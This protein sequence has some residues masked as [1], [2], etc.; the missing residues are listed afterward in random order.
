MSTA[1]EQS[2]QAVEAFWAAMN[3][4]DFAAAA[5]HLS[6]DFVLE[7]PQSRERIRGR[8]NFAAINQSYPANGRWQFT[9]HRLVAEGAE[10]VSDVG[11]TDGSVHARAITFSTVRDG[12][13]VRQIEYW[14]DAYEAPAWRAQWVERM[15]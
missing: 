6:E 14:P 2:R 7:W 13:I 10:V 12:Q 4:N 5:L 8:A 9:I 3:T 1:S 11:V 15:G